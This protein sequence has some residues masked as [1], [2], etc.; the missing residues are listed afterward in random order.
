MFF[1]ERSL[2]RIGYTPSHSSRRN[3][4]TSSRNSRTCSERWPAR[5]ITLKKKP[6]SKTYQMSVCIYVVYIRNK[7]TK[8]HKNLKLCICRRSRYL[9]KLRRKKHNNQHCYQAYHYSLYYRIINLY[10]YFLPRN[11][12]HLLT[13]LPNLNHRCFLIHTTFGLHWLFL[14]ILMMIL[15]CRADRCCRHLSPLRR[16]Y[17]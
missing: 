16:R 8:F 7:W 17:R 2:T 13:L 9:E 14:Y 10:V 15:F 1:P 6:H 11:K 4:W 5:K 12:Q 3:I